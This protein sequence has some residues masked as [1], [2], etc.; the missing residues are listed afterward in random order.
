MSIQWLTITQKKCF[1]LNSIIICIPDHFMWPTC[2]INK[3]KTEMNFVGLLL[4][5]LSPEC[6]KYFFL[7]CYR[8]SFILGW[9]MHYLACIMIVIFQNG[10][11]ILDFSME[12]P[13]SH[14]SW[15]SIF[16]SISRSIMK[17]IERFVL[18][19][20]WQN[21]YL[22]LDS[23]RDRNNSCSSEPRFQV[24]FPRVDALGSGC[25]CLHN[26]TSVFEF[27]LPCVCEIHEEKGILNTNIPL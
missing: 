2:F 10:C 17:N 1:R 8:L 7:F 20:L 11:S 4:K 12:W 5:G 15:T 23:V 6:L 9:C 14:Y 24:W 25:L 26:F 19:D 16:R 18:I 13:L 27:L 22:F 21:F 3:Y